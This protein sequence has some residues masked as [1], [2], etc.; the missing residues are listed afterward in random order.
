MDERLYLSRYCLIISL[1]IFFVCSSVYALQGSTAA[2]GSNA[3]AVHDINITGRG[4][5]VGLITAKNVQ[6]DHLAFLDPNGQTGV[7]NHDYTGNGFAYDFHDTPFAGI[8]KSR[9]SYDHPNDI[10]V[11]PDSV[12]HCGRVVNNSDSLYFDDLQDAL[13]DLI[14]TIGCKVI[15]TGIQLPPTVDP[16]WSRMYD[17]YAEHYDVVFANAAGNFYPNITVFGDCYNGITT[18]GLED[19]ITDNYFRVG[20]VSNPGPTIDGRRKPEVM[21]PSTYQVAPGYSSGSNNYWNTGYGDGA[22]SWSVPHTAGVAALLLEYAN[23]T[24][25]PNDGHNVVIK[26]VIVNSTFPNIDDKAGNPTNPANPANV[27]HNERGYGRIDALRAF[28]T[29]SA[30]RIVK[31]VTVTSTA[32]WAYDTVSSGA[33]HNYFIAGKKNERFVLTVTW[34]RVIKKSGSNYSMEVPKFNLDITVK[35]P[36][37]GT[38]F[39]ETDDGNNLEKIDL[40]LP[41]DGNYTVSLENTTSKSRAYGLAFELLPPLTGDFD[42]NYIVDGSDLRQ[43][44]LDWLTA[45][46]DTDIVPDTPDGVVNWLDFAKFADH[47]FEIDKRYYDPCLLY[48]SKYLMASHCTTDEKLYLWSS[49]DGKDW[50]LLNGG[51]SY[52]PPSYVLRD[53]S[54]FKHTDGYYYIVYTNNNIDPCNFTGNRFGV[55]RSP[56]LTTWS[57]VCWVSIPNSVCVWAPEWFVDSDGSVYVFVAAV[58]NGLGW[59]FYETHPTNST[60]TSWSASV[61]ITGTNLLDYMIDPFVVKIGNTYYLWYARQTVSGNFIGYAS[62]NSLTSGYTIIEVNDWAGWGSKE[63]ECLIQLD[64]GTWRIYFDAVLGAVYY[65]ESTDNWA[66]WTT[67]ILIT[68]DQS[69]LTPGHGTVMK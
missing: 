28:N 8:I 50:D 31:S 34:N 11:A 47:W 14:H 17:Y 61:L 53:P 54:I 43:I 56:D 39:S 55:A 65:S 27:W 7:F 24:A 22:T 21:A 30:G 57:H 32:G 35:N 59:R 46:P 68:D 37:G 29:L 18:G 6:A 64:D 67:P 38:I 49:N 10:G 3:Q 2:N 40:I 33:T 45:G 4:I 52:T 1:L 62:S 16:N 44:A 63:G 23:Q 26:A 9:G 51:S 15:V 58:V 60:F 13:Y 48:A 25:E 19:P 5:K 41:A 69:G 66:T 20:D 42:I 12:I 36:F